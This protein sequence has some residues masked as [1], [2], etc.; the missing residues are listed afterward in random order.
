MI[1]PI[2]AGAIGLAIAAAAVWALF[3]SDEPPA[4]QLWDEEDD[5]QHEEDR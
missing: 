2:I 3:R 4:P 1:D 5:D